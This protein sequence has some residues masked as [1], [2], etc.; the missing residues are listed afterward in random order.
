MDDSLVNNKDVGVHYDKVTRARVYLLGE[1]LHYGD[2][3][4]PEEPLAAA[5][6]RLTG[7]MAAAADLRPG[8]EVLDV[9]CG[10]GTPAV[11]V[12]RRYGCHVTGISISE[13]GLKTARQSVLEWGVAD[14]VRFLYGDGMSNGLL[15]ASCDRVWVMESSHLMGDKAALLGECARVLRGGGKLVL[16]DIIAHV[17]FPI[18][19]VMR[20]D[21]GVTSCCW[22]KSSAGPGWTRSKNTIGS[23]RPRAC[24]SPGSMTSVGRFGRRSPPGGGMRK[25]SAAK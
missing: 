2:F 11:T 25:R 6:A 1:D 24:T 17:V 21:M 22:T 12:A 5:T 16:C 18:A 15:D 9:G 14:R 23:P 4:D 10:I 8:L 3:A 20:Y 7:R 19:D 13:V